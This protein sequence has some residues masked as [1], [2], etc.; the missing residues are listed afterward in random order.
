MRIIHR[1][2]DYLVVRGTLL[3]RVAFGPKGGGELTDRV[4]PGMSVR[5]ADGTTLGEFAGVLR[6]GA[7]AKPGTDTTPLL[8]VRG[9]RGSHY[10][11]PVGE[12]A[13][14]SA[15]RVTLSAGMDE[16]RSRGW[17]RK[18]LWVAQQEAW[19]GAQDRPEKAS[20]TR[21]TDADAA[22]DHYRQTWW[23]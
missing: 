17:S 6:P 23:T 14:V 9:A 5:T 3:A 10:W 11:V 8:Q 21:Y 22:T 18:P 20:A 19:G 13:E 4:Y 12:I 7:D 2:T 16:V 1:L 15:L